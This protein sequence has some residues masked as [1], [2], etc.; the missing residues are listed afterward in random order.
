MNYAEVLYA[1]RAIILYDEKMVEKYRLNGKPEQDA[2]PGVLREVGTPEDG[3]EYFG[4]FMVTCHV[5]DDGEVLMVTGI[6]SGVVADL[7]HMPGAE[8][9]IETC[10]DVAL[11]AAQQDVMP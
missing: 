1:D 6:P 8:P 7:T 2:Q 4:L 10:R 9:M 11:Q 3:R 5:K